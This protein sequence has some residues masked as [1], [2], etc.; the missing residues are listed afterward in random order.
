MPWNTFDYYTG[1]YGGNYISTNE[2]RNRLYM[3][4]E[5]RGKPL[6]A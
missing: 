2:C 6:W 3:I 1:I 4:V 5:R